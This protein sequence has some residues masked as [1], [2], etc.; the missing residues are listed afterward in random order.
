M[1]TLEIANSTFPA[2]NI[3]DAYNAC[4]PDVPLEPGDPRYLD[5]TNVR[6]GFNLAKVIARRIRRT[7]LPHF[8]RQL[9]TG[10]RGCGKST[11]L[12]QLQ[13]QLKNDNFL[14]VYVDVEEVLDLGDISYLDVLLSIAH[15]I[16]KA[17]ANE[18]LSIS[19][20]LVKNLDEWFADKILTKE[21]RRDV[22]E[23]LK[24][25][26]AVEP[27]VPLLVRMLVAISGQIRS[28]SSRKL[29]IRQILEKELSIFISR[30]NDLIDAVQTQLE[31][32]NRNSL[33]VIVDGLEKML[34]R[35]T[36]EGQST[37]T[38]LFVEHA[39]QLKAPNCHI[40]YTVPISLLYNV[41]L[42]DSFS[43][44]DV[45]PMVKIVYSDG[46]T[47]FENGRNALFQLLSRRMKIEKIFSPEQKI[48]NFIEMCGGSIRDL[49]RLVRYACDE[50]DDYIS[51]QHV[52]RAIKRMIREYDRLI[53]DGDL[54]LLRKISIQRQIPGHTVA[55]RLLHK[56]LVLEY[57]SENE[58]RWADLHPCV[59]H[60]PRVQEI[61][62]S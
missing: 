28:G 2:D 51:E 59:R 48:W 41:N 3:D 52:E 21:Q 30:L 19:Q 25:E 29:E 9:I 39:E 27:K 54:D 16:A 5:F 4:N 44:T 55:G 24:T 23:T 35:E 8:H 7:K 15:T 36:K 61:L 14:A 60:A 22:E 32:L 11:E 50:T 42:G 13:A 53:E 56:R 40:I 33:V 58:E 47:P 20:N 43:E 37:Y 31:R 49:L 46:K 18:G 38:E 45:I 17:V 10:H 26:F 57:I 6:G 34:Y 1:L 62:R 12:K